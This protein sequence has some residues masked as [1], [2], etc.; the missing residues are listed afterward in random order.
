[1]AESIRRAERGKSKVGADTT[2]K[3]GTAPQ[4]D[5]IVLAIDIGGSHVK[6]RLSTGSEKRR[7][8]SSADMTAAEM[9]GEMTKLTA[10]WDYD[11]IGIGYP[12]PVSDNRPAADPFNLGPS[13]K[14]F[15]FGAARRSGASRSAR[16]SKNYKPRCC[17]IT[18]SSGAAMPAN[19]RS[20]HQSAAVATTRMP[21]P[22]AFVY[23]STRA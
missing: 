17:R 14:D 21:L 20:C 12:G 8:D 22:V 2:A 18:L 5:R 15:D 11:A 13:W 19:S 10:D 9:V 1:M 4:R 16:W 3:R 23:G 6:A 7:I